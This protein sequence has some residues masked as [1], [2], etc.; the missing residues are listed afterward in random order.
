[1]LHNK[2]IQKEDIDTL[3]SNLS[4]E[5]EL[6]GGNKTVDIYLVGGAAIILSFDYRASTLDIDAC[7]KDNALLNSA[8]DNVSS[9]LNLPK[10]WINQDFIKTPS[11]SPIIKEKAKL[12][13]KYGNYINILYLDAKYLIAMK[14]KSSR[15][16]GGDLD[17]IIMMIYELRY[18]NMNIS[19]KEIINAYRELYSDFSNTY[20]YFLERA[21]LAFEVPVEDF[22]RLFKK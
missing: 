5:Y 12:F 3:F 14:L 4:K 8:I 21:K 20:D 19:Y 17:D 18:K 9:K 1:M 16:T 13:A 15:P 7:F 6:L 10:D 22:E 2:L 11:Y